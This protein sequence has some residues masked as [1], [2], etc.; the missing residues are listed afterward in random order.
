MK[1][2]DFYPTAAEAKRAPLVDLASAI[3]ECLKT[4]PDLQ[5]LHRRNFLIHAADQYRAPLADFDEALQLRCAEAWS[6]LNTAGLICEEPKGDRYF[7]TR[8]GLAVPDRQGVARWVEER[9][10]PES[11]LH[12][13]LRGQ[14]LILFRQGIFDTAVFESF[15]TLEVA[16]RAAASYGDEKIGT[17]LAQAAFSPTNGPLIDLS[18]EVGERQALMYLM[19]GA[20]GSYKNPHSHRRVAIGAGEAREMLLLASHLL[21]IVDARR[22]A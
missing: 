2:K 21:R 22:L 16:I 6:W 12:E 7:V 19:A 17:A 8:A 10:L 9:E 4:E 5:F 15:K 14:A 13:Q 3:L 11:M 20:I 1:L 18:A